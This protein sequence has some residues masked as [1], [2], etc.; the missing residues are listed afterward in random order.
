M[1]NRSGFKVVSTNSNDAHVY[2]HTCSPNDDSKNKPNMY[3]YFFTPLMPQHHSITLN[4]T[5][6]RFNISLSQSFFQCNYV[7]NVQ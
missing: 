1:V 4:N 2:E 6:H 7:T 3:N 5:V